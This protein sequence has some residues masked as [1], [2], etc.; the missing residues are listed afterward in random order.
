MMTKKNHF[1][2]I[3]KTVC[4][5]VME[6]NITQKGDQFVVVYNLG[7]RIRIINKFY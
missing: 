1:S 5:N 6:K 7:N 4:N 3:R 2:T